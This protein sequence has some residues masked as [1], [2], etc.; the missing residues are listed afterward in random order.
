MV[1]VESLIKLSDNVSINIDEVSIH[2]Q[3]RQWREVRR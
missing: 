2:T 1:F 3:T